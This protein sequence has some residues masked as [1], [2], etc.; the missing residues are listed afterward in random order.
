[1]VFGVLVLATLGAFVVTQRLKRSTPFV[2]RVHYSGPCITP[3]AASNRQ[4][5]RDV[6]SPVSR[7]PVVTMRFSL[8]KR[9]T[10]VTVSVVNAAGDDVRILARDRTLRRGV[11]RFHWNGRD[12]SGAVVPDGPY[13]LRVALQDQGRALT[14]P[15]TITVDT[16]PPRPRLVSVTPS[17]Y[18]S[19]RDTLQVQY[20]GPVHPKPDLRIWRT[21]GPKPV[22]V[23]QINKKGAQGASYNGLLP[24]GTYLVSVTMYD[25]AGNAGS[26]PRTLPPRRSQAQPGS[27]FSVHALTVSGPPAPVRAGSVVRFKVGPV[28]RRSRWNLTSIDGGSPVARGSG[29]GATVAL[30]VPPRAATGLYTFRVQAA[31]HIVQAPLVV[32]GHTRG[33][34]LVVLPAIV[35]QGLNPIDD[36][37]DGFPNLLSAGDS[38][39]LV[40]HPFA[41]AAGPAGV[42]QQVGPLLR[43]LDR[44]RLPYD[45]TTDLALAQGQGP[46]LGKASG[47]L[48]PGDETWLTDKVDLALRSYVEKG[49]NV[50]SFGNDSFRR[51]VEL[52]PTELSAP[53]APERVNVFGE[54]TAQAHLPAAAPLVIQPAPKIPL[55]AGTDGIFGN[56]DQLEQNQRLVGGTQILAAAGRDPKHPAFVAY[57]LG[58]G[59]VVRVGTPQWASQLTTD[60]E[61]TDVTR[62]IWTLLSQ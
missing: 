12:D 36:D 7:W 42:A 29:S 2:E 49:G 17:S 50:A 25:R 61:L 22:V 18:L 30:R 41:S 56:F 11:H 59:T 52:S 9:Q 23:A 31:G 19:G 3:G 48:F 51:I 10:R 55:F 6:F 28:P 27:G 57:K 44:E 21:D 32:R 54:E 47:V 45:I 14:A 15:R 5:S 35:W 20:R 16:K 53:T 40:N 46:Q 26:V 13:R 1:V 38:V 39:S 34:V 4:C 33:A 62:R 60:T 58:N 8:P 24:D 37:N 43:F